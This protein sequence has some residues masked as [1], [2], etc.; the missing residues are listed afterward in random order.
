MVCEIAASKFLKKCFLCF[1]DSSDL[2][3]FGNRLNSLEL[4]CNLD[5]IRSFYF[6]FFFPLKDDV[7]LV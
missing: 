2:K 4:C 1:S 3:A 5:T 7:Q 6:H